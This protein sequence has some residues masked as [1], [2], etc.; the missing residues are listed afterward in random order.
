LI[1]ERPVGKFSR[2][3]LTCT[4]RNQKILDPP[5]GVEIPMHLKLKNIFTRKTVGSAKK[6]DNP[7]IDG[8]PVLVN[9]GGQIGMPR[10]RRFW[11]RREDPTER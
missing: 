2:L 3:C 8:C 10:Y 4:K 1:K 9:D 6:N 5:K 7:F 11:K